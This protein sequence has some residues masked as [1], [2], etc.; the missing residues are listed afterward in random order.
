MNAVTLSFNGVD[1]R[2]VH[3]TQGS[4]AESGNKQITIMSDGQDYQEL[5]LNSFTGSLV[6][7]P[8][9]VPS[10]NSGVIN[11]N[12]PM[13]PIEGVVVPENKAAVVDEEPPTPSE[14]GKTS[15]DELP[16]GQTQLSF[17]KPKKPLV[18]KNKR[19]YSHR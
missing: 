4:N 19:K 15:D 17:G 1:F 10:F 13:L 11:G 5:K 3:D 6:I 7:S 14:K 9:I 2:L 12:T 18:G 8:S 16:S